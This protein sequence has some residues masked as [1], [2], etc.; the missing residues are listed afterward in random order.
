NERRAL[1]GALKRSGIVRQFEARFHRRDGKII[2]AEAAARV[3]RGELNQV[4]YF[5]GVLEDITARKEAEQA[6]REEEARK[7]AIVNSAL[8]A[9]VSINPQGQITE[10]NPTAEK[11]FGRRRDDVL[12]KDLAGLIIPHS[13]REQHRRGLERYLSTGTGA[14]LG[15]RVELTAMRADGKEFP[16]ELAITRADLDRQT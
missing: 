4:T 2:W 9:V 11:T 1:L 7:A 6:L 5:E 10:F 14:M 13:L 8:D 16:V 3:I 12:G 15:K